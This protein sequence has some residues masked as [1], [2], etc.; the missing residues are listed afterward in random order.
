MPYLMGGF[1]DLEAIGGDRRGLRRRRRRPDRA[2]RAVLRPAGRRPGDPRRRHARAGGGRHAA[3]RARRSPRSLAERLPVVLM[4]YAN[5]VLARGAERFADELAERRRQRADRARPAAR[6]RTARCARRA[7]PPALALVPLVAPD[8]AG[9]P[10]GRDRRAARVDFSTRC[11]SP[12]PPASAPSV[13][14]SL[15]S[16]LERAK[17]DCPVPVAVGFGISTPEQAAEAADAGAD[18]VIVGSWLVR[19][20]GEAADPRDR[21]RR[22]GRGAG[23]GPAPLG[24]APHGGAAHTHRRPRRL[25][26]PL[27][28]RRQGLRRLHDHRADAGDRRGRLHARAAPARPAPGRTE[29]AL[30]TGR[31]AG[32]TQS[33]VLRLTL[34]PRLERACV[35]SPPKSNPL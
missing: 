14:R 1:P 4:C 21:R 32:W 9:R 18:G 31:F 25:G 16:V 30:R 17:R 5:L 8:H 6:A 29:D 26:R 28:A 12:G 13:D 2:R 3:R 19:A 24:F 15:A 11:R 35:E 34:L 7:T 33:A 22:A 10:D 20:A 27:G 23:R